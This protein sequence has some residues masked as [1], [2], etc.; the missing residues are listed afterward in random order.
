MIG[1]GPWTTRGWVGDA[2]SLLSIRRLRNRQALSLLA[3]LSP[4]FPF[5]H[6]VGIE[7]DA[8][9]TAALI[10]ELEGKDT[11]EV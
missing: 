9:R 2:R 7:A 8:D 6:L 5:I 4:H 10:K 1:W 3:F 11:A